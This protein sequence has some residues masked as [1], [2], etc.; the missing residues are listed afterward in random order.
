MDEQSTQPIVPADKQSVQPINPDDLAA[1]TSIFVSYLEQFNLPTDNIIAVTEERKIVASNLSSFLSSLPIESKRDARYLSKFIG[2]TAIGL[3]D[4]ALNYVWNEVVLNLRKKASIYGIDLFFDAAVGGKNREAYKDEMDLGGLKDNV[5]LDT[6]RKLEL[7]SNVVYRKLDYILTMRNEVAASHPNVESIGGF[8]LLGWLQT[9]IKDV[10]QDRPSDSAI[11]IRALVDN[12]KSKRDVIDEITL[13]R[14]AKE[15][16][17]LSLPHVHNLLITIFGIFVSPTSEQVLRKNISSIA[18]LV[19]QCASD[20][21]KY[22]IGTQIDGYRTNL[23]EEKLARGVEFLGIVGGLM[24]E[25][26]PA[27]SIALNDLAD[28]LEEKHEGRDNFYNEPAVM[29]QILQYCRS[30]TDIPKEVLPKLVKIVL[31]CRIGRGL[32]YCNG[33]SP[34]GCSLY[35]QF[36]KLLDDDGV[37]CCVNIFF[38]PEI[39][40]KLANRICQMHLKT[41]LENLKSIVISERLRDCIIFLLQDISNAYVAGSKKDFRE[42]TAS[43]I[44]WRDTST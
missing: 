2:A 11:K 32:K 3:F 27:R 37:A 17:F 12:L 4:A 10:L 23:H 5:L 26:L 33:V 31:R 13:D 8:E 6:C 22:K 25:S 28:Q 16:R 21:V 40:S 15:L 41:I 29:K 18:P 38:D 34:G 9:C 42:L 43:F 39:N 24:Y 36:L 30:S 7:I 44:S 19:W 1:D 35:D 14:V 20:R